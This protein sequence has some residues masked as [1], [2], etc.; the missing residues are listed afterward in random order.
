MTATNQATPLFDWRMNTYTCASK[1]LL[2]VRQHFYMQY[3]MF[4]NE[5]MI[6]GPNSST[7]RCERPKN[8]PQL[9]RIFPAERGSRRIPVAELLVG[10]PDLTLD[11]RVTPI[12]K[13]SPQRDLLKQGMHRP[14]PEIP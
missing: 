14:L 8:R 4:V 13:T 9:D 6:G 7:A 2:S 10:S 12:T 3:C 11:D 1:M 5:K